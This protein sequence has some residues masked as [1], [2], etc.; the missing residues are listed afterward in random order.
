MDWKPIETLTAEDGIVVGLRARSV[1]RQPAFVGQMH[2][3]RR[4]ALIDVW[5]GRWVVCTHWADL[6]LPK[7]PTS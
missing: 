1:G 6:N 4:D 5:T 3:L 7:G 2:N